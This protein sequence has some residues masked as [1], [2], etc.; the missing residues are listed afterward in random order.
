MHETCKC[1]LDA[2]TCN[3]KQCWNE[4]KCRC[5]CKKLVDEGEYDKWFIWNP[6]NC[7]CDK[8]SHLWE[9]LDY[10]NCRLRKILVDKLVQECTDNIDEV[11]MAKITLDEHENKYEIVCECF[12][13]LF[14]VLFSI[15]FTISM[16][17][18]TYFIHYKFINPIKKVAKVGCS[19][20][21]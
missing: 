2:S 17:I 13:T 10:E 5:E 16:G 21:C 1:R 14:I 7:E 6:S 12:C 20:I 11:K 19:R 18:G 9:Y 15:I 4:D 3:N 8:S